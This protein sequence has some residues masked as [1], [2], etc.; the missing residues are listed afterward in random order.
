MRYGPIY[1]EELKE[2]GLA[3]DTWPLIVEYFIGKLEAQKAY[4]DSAI[5]AMKAECPTAQDFR[6]AA[7]FMEHWKPPVLE[8]PSDKASAGRA[9]SGEGQ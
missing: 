6:N 1:A 8:Q 5:R 2:R 4:Y 9:E 3:L 7:H